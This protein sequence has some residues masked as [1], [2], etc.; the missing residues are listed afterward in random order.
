MCYY[1]DHLEL[2]AH[3][4]NKKQ[5]YFLL[6]LLLN[7]KLSAH[8][9]DRYYYLF[10][11]VPGADRSHLSTHGSDLQWPRPAVAWSGAWVPSRGLRLG[12]SGESTG[13]VTGAL[14]LWLCRK[15]SPRRQKIVKQ[16]FIKRK[17]VQYMWIGTRAD[18]EGDFL[19]RALV[20]VWIT[21]LGPFSQ[22]P[23]AQSFWFARFMVHIWHISGSFYVCPHI[24]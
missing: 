22:F 5:S 8:N 14:A 1:Q 6:L 10:I 21:F 4:N 17:R 19:S 15:E 3:G 12:R 23:F 20:A 2:L 7:L 11:I 16:V 9:A 24:T 18:S 13:P